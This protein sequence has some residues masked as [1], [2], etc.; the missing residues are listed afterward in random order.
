MTN[1]ML[2]RREWMAASATGIGILAAGAPS[3]AASAAITGKAPFRLWYNNDTTNIMNVDSPFHQRGEPLTDEAIIGS[4]DEVADKGVDAY[5]LSPGLGHVPFWQSEVDPDHFQWWMK[6]TGLELDAYGRYLLDGGDM[7]RV[8]VQRCRHYGMAP[9]VSLRM[10]DVHLLEN[11]GKKT[12]QSIWVSRFYE[13]NPDLLLERDHPQRRPKGYYPWRGQNWAKEEVRRR[14]LAFLT[15]LCENYDL[16]GI[17]L[18]WLRDQHIFPKDFPVDERKAIMAGF[19]REVRDV[20][21][22]STG[23]GHRRYLAV[24][25]PLALRGHAEFGF[26]V[27]RAMEAG[28]DILNCSGWFFSQPRT[29]L[30]E[31]R[32][33]A[34]TAT[35]FQELT[36]VAGSLRLVSDPSSSGY[37]TDP[38]P[39]TSEEM[40]FTAANLAYKRGADGISLFNFVYYRMGS[41][42]LSWLVREPPFHVLPRLVD[43]EW[44]SS[45]SQLNWLAPW[46]Y[47][48][49]VGQAI[50]TGRSRDYQLDLALPKREL[51]ASAT[52]RVVCSRPVGDAKLV[53]A[54]NGTQME[55]TQEVGAPFN[56]PYDRLLGGHEHRRAWI[57]PIGL[58]GEGI[59]TVRI[60]LDQATGPVTPVWLDLAV[61]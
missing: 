4:I 36:H 3:A 38:F 37:G 53:A 19:L 49:Q 13:E 29:D 24:R 20:V 14:K 6:K 23:P 46:S 21:D 10:N 55:A 2:N 26:D 22:R 39:R 30:A 34:P 52:L 42:H 11:V 15:E 51:R 18:D 16:A 7:V 45:Q 27:G 9:F 33:S 31:I 32:R 40:F 5:A 43:R 61:L 25:I 50:Q 48:K 41:G 8:L 57:C 47:L 54:V 60:G 58:L 44:L 1:R 17:E 59:N 12:P 28:V 56:Y 35:I